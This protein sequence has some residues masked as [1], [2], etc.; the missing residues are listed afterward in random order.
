MDVERL[1]DLER[2]RAQT[3]CY[4]HGYDEVNPFKVIIFYSISN[5]F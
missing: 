4:Y 3:W 1:D 2:C 5:Y